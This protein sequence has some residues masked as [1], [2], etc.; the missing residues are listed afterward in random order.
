MFYC[1]AAGV[2][3]VTTCQPCYKLYIGELV[4]GLRIVSGN[5]CVQLSRFQTGPRY[6]GGGLPVAEHFNLPEHNQVHG[7][8]RP[9]SQALSPLL[10]FQRQ[11]MQTRE[12]H[13]TRMDM[14]VFVMRQKKEGRKNDT[15]RKDYS[16]SSWVH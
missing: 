5:T 7:M 6:Q 15:A 4:E 13:G 2:V 12:S 11:G 9:R 14:P 8:R 1:T 10:P 3:Y 16:F